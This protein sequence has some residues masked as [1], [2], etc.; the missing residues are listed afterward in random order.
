[1]AALWL[2]VVEDVSFT[3]KVESPD[4]PALKQGRREEQRWQQKRRSS[5]HCEM[6]T[7]RKR[8]CGG[9]GRPSA[10][11]SHQLRCVHGEGLC[12]VVEYRDDDEAAGA[13]ADV[14]VGESLARRSGVE[15][16]RGK[17]TAC[18]RGMLLQW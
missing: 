16:S 12:C 2:E 5:R 6:T 7:R 8:R 15:V 1:M 3:W 10:T 13:V 14:A 17:G 4:R 18:L 9:E 11:H